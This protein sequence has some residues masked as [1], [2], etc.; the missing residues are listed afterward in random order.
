MKNLI[1]ILLVFISC[2][3]TGLAI[4]ECHKS[5]EKEQQFNDL[6]STGAKATVIKEY[7][8]DS[9]EHV[10]YQ[11]RVIPDNEAAKRLALSKSYADSLEK[12]LK[13]SLN[14]IDQV[15]KVNAELKA[16]VQLKPNEA[17]NLVYQDRWLKLNYN[18]DSNQVA[19]N[20]DVGLN[21]ARYSDKSW[22][23]GK[24]TNYIDVYS[25][26]PRVTIKGLQT[27]RVEEKKESPFSVGV[28]LGYGIYQQNNQIK[29]TPYVGLGLNLKLFN[30]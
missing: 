7:I 29:T 21:I 11:D 28:Q 24:K 27:F 10:V 3:A 18:Q 17:N 13:I 14:K 19:V 25:D 2:V 16:K 9:I 12:A 22:F 20:Y 26:D 23:L 30:F 15:T 5:T 1:T 8:R 4:R 6:V